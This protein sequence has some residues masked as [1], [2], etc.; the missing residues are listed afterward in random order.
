M[1]MSLFLISLPGH[2]GCTLLCVSSINPRKRASRRLEQQRFVRYGS[3]L[4][5]KVLSNFELLIG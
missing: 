5:G 2:A 1:I 4:E 3:H